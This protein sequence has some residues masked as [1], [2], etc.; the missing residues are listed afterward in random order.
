MRA[1]SSGEQHR[2]PMKLIFKPKKL[3]KRDEREMA[4]GIACTA[5]VMSRL[6]KE[7]R[8]LAE[9]SLRSLQHA[10]ATHE[11]PQESLASLG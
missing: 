7:E 6:P 5:S 8:E 3:S 10:S 1:L 11:P 9:S 4:I 2:E